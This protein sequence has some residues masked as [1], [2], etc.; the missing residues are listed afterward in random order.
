MPLNGRMQCL[1]QVPDMEFKDIVNR[2]IVNLKNCDDEPIHIPGSI[3][4]HGFLL[5]ANLQDKRIRFCSENILDFT[6]ASHEQV[7]GKSLDV[8]FDA[9]FM[10]ELDEIKNLLPNNSRIVNTSLQGHELSVTMHISETYVILEGEFQ[11][12]DDT[13]DTDLYTSSRQL[14]SYMEDSYT[15]VQLCAVVANAI[16]RI[17]GYD[18]VMIYRFDKDYNGEV[19]AESREN[20]LEPFLGLHYPH[21]DIPPQARELYI[22]NQLRIIGDTGYQPAS[23]YTMDD[24]GPARLDLS[25]SVLRSVSPI[26]VQYLLNMGVGATLN[27]SLLHKGKLWGLI[28]CHHYSPKYISQGIRMAAK[29][30]GHFITSQIDVR[31]I[32]EEYEI[33]SQVNSACDELTSEKPE[34]NNASLQQLADNPNILKLCNA[35]GVSILVGEHVYKSG[36]TPGND[37]IKM[38]SIY[39]QEY[40]VSEPFFTNS[41]SRITS[42]LPYLAT[43]FPGI[44][45]MPLQKDTNDCVI[46][47]RPETLSE[48]H[49]AGDPNKAIEKDSNGLSPRK[50]FLSWKEIVKNT[51]KPWLLSELKASR[52][53]TNFLQNHLRSIQLFDEEE[54]QRKLAHALTET[55]AELENIN[56]ISTH[57]LQEP[58]RKIRMMSS[59]ILNDELKALPGCV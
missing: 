55:N 53:F 33:A 35:A 24:G 40:T 34:F 49:W 57:D 21:T 10:R 9:S 31:L 45:Y 28:A 39:L 43:K 11:I 26:H 13:P 56:W 19:I 6:G 48:I 17:T 38:L 2:N 37:E 16:K 54:K 27:I 7:L 32:N 15:L 52:S 36:Q 29:L 20:H 44:N 25:N 4:P 50:S 30:Q 3:Q 58:L 41:V 12:T 51:S 42:D 8:L 22:R 47:Y 59:M 46:W 23:I 18:R 5:A 14:L 1:I